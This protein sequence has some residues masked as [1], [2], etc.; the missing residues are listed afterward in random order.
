MKPWEKYAQSA[1][2]ASEGP[3]AKYAQQSQDKPP[4]Q[5]IE[6]QQPPQQDPLAGMYEQPQTQSDRPQITGGRG[7]AGQRTQQAQFDA[8]LAAD[9]RKQMQEMAAKLTELE[10]KYERDVPGSAV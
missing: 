3:W 5:Q 2:P 10:L 6:P 1:Q 8:Q 4:A 7:I 9:M